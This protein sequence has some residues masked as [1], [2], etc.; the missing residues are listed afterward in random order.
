MKSKDV[1]IGE[2][3]A[4]KVSGRICK[5]RVKRARLSG[6]GWIGLNTETGREVTIRTAARLRYRI[7]TQWDRVR[8]AAMR[9]GLSDFAGIFK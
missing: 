7:V 6:G 3:Y 1:R 4:V 8:A 2:T 5:V 9:D